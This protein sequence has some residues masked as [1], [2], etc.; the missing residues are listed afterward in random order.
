MLTIV[1]WL[2]HNKSGRYSAYNANIWAR[3]IDRNL[4]MPHRFILMT[5]RPDDAYDL[6]IQPI[7]LWDDWRG[8]VK[9]KNWTA[10]QP[11]CY[12]RLKAF[13]E[14]AREI[15]GDRFVSIDLDV[16]PTAPLDPLFNRTEDFLIIHRHRRR[17]TDINNYIASMWMMN[18][19]CRKQVW[20]DFKGEQSIK[21]SEQY[22]GTDQAWIRHKLGPDEAGWTENDGVF[23][24]LRV[25]QG[26]KPPAGSRLIVFNGVQ[27]PHDFPTAEGPKCGHCGTPIKV[28][29]PYRLISTMRNTHP[30]VA[31]AY[32]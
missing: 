3:M 20:E 13:S 17:E 14:E 28:S 22:M 5:D 9:T 1:G 4:S 7:P 21:E 29:P 2:W 31:R 10:A 25:P 15:F 23:S 18:A 12:V 11:N 16:I 26:Q 19:G 30:W 27:K 24:M 32:Q 6:L 8:L